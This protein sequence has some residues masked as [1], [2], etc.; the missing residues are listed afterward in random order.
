MFNLG[1]LYLGWDEVARMVV[2]VTGATAPVE[3]V[4]SSAFTG[5]AFLAGR[6]ELDLG[7]IEE[8]LGFAPARDPDWVRGQFKGALSATWA[9]LSPPS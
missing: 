1:S 5:P 8:R 2:E 7:R 3:S 9:R 6:W 4:P